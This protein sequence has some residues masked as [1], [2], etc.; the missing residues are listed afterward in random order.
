MAKCAQFALAASL[1]QERIFSVNNDV[2]PCIEVLV[3]NLPPQ[4]CT[5]LTKYGLSSM[6]SAYSWRWVSVGHYRFD[7]DCCVVR[8]IGEEYPAFG[9]VKAIL[10]FA[11]CHYLVFEEIKTLLYDEHFGAY[12]CV[13]VARLYV[14]N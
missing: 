14:A 12:S 9:I 11:E 8:A 13:C 5:A 3:S 1:L 4:V 10:Y 7:I 2:G 6:E